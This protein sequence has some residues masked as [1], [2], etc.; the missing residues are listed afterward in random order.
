MQTQQFWATNIKFLRNRKRFS[1]D[2]MAAALNISRSKLNAHENGQ[3]V[4]PTVE[5]LL[6]FSAYFKMSVDTL[7]KVDL[8]KLSELK[9][10]ELESGNDV[11]VTG[12]KIRVLATTVDAQNRDQ[13]EFVP[14]KAKAGYLAGYSD[15][16]FISS[17]PIF[18]MPHLPKDKKFRMFPTT[19]DS[20]YPIPES[21]MV[22]GAFVDDWM[23]IK[24][25]TPCIVITKEEGIVFK[26]VTNHI[27]ER[28]KLG[29]RSLN[30]VYQPYEINA[31]EVVE[32]WRFV[33]YISDAIPEAEVPL[34]EI[35]RVV[36]EMRQDVKK[37]LTKK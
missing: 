29:L 26:M 22:I 28:R 12:S 20:M 35:A 19:G 10:R 16:E 33:N 37:L 9:V 27:K 31:G 25:E 13:I 1:Q 7:L 18:S 8:P 21:S 4:N 36:N 24:A 34:Q 23:S 15:P 17:L 11:Y 2:E 5:D 14:Q 32:I 6:N 30:T 3:S